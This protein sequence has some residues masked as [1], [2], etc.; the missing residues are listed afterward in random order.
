LGNLP[1]SIL[2]ASLTSLI[3]GNPLIMR[4]AT[5]REQQRRCE[6]ECRQFE[7]RFSPSRILADYY[8]PVNNAF[9]FK[10]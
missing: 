3:K 5:G 9:N 8:A 10:L 1:A 7:H 4:S 2:I 6:R